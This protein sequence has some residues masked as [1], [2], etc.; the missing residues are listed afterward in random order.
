MNK[1][2]KQYVDNMNFM[3]TLFNDGDEIDVNNITDADA[4]RIFEKLDGDLSPENLHCDGEISA[5]AVRAKKRHFN[6][7]I[8]GLRRLGFDYQ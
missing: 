8:A 7:V 5:G 1:D 4:K 2:L 6:G 3:A